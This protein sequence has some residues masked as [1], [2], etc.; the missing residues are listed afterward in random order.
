MCP[1]VSVYKIFTTIKLQLQSCMF[2]KIEL[3]MLHHYI[4]ITLATTELEDNL[5][6]LI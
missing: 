6:I 4:T 1:L 5:K 3:R 2:P